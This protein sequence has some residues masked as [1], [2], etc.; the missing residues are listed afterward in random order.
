MPRNYSTL[1]FLAYFGKG[2]ESRWRVIDSH[3]DSG[4]TRTPRT[5]RNVPE[6]QGQKAK[7]SGIGSDQMGADL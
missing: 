3:N 2:V 4:D 5:T 7:T 6:R 1:C